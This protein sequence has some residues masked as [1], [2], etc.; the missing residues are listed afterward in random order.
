[1]RDWR[2]SSGPDVAKRRAA[3]LRRLRAYFDACALIEVDTP[4]LSQAAVSDVHIESLAVKS[5]LTSEPLYLHTSPEFFMKRML[6]AGYP[7]IYSICRVFRDGEVGRSH[8]PEFTMLEWYRL[9]FNLNSII[10]DTTQAIAIALQQPELSSNYET[11]NYQDAFLKTCGIDPLSCSI[12]ALADVMAADQQLRASLGN[13]H[14]AWLDLILTVKILPSLA[15]DKL[16][17]LQHYPAD[18]AALARNCPNDAAVADRFEIFLGST[19]IANGYVELIDSKIQSDRI[20]SDQTYRKNHGLPKR[21]VDQAFID[22]LEFGLP[23]CAGVAMGL[24]RL[25]M[26][27]DKTSD[28]NDVITFA[29]EVT[30]D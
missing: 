23:A 5:S 9:G 30:D 18:Q 2:P 21:P 7:D 29:F 13:E 15:T 11:L 24:E 22:A 28:I 20:A 6:A 17:V 19:E 25:Q 1:M 12:D 8:Q 16:T 10:Q 26:L 14:R 4:A 27:Y 3:L